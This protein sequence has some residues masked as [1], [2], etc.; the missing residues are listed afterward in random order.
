MCFGTISLRKSLCL[1]L[2][3]ITPETFSS[4]FLSLPR[5][6]LK[7]KLTSVCY[8]QLSSLSMPEQQVQQQPVFPAAGALCSCL[9]A[10]L[11]SSLAGGQVP[12]CCQG[13]GQ[14]GSKQGVQR[15]SPPWPQLC[16]K[17]LVCVSFIFL[18]CHQHDFR[19]LLGGPKLFILVVKLLA[20]PLG[21]SASPF[22]GL[23]ERQE[24]FSEEWQKWRRLSK[25]ALD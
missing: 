2:E 24:P 14:G 18:S 1:C 9:W 17:T 6:L 21:K 19:Q 12:V 8:F 13:V 10:L 3:I 16:L 5:Q 25:M 23:G 15:G 20:A 22:H 11:G 7:P 4:L